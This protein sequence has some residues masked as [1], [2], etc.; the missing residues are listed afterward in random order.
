MSKLEIPQVVPC[1]I[2]R[3]KRVGLDTWEIVIYT[4]KSRIQLALAVDMLTVLLPRKR[5]QLHARWTQTLL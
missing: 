1:V 5:A 2:N 3:M 4:P